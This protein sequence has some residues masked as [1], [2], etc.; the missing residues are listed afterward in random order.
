MKRP[1]EDTRL[2][3]AERERARRAAIKATNP[4][5][6]AKDT[7]GSRVRMQKHRANKRKHQRAP[8]RRSGAGSAQ[9]AAAPSVQTLAARGAA[10]RDVAAAEILAGMASASAP[11]SHLQQ[12]HRSA[13]AQ[14]PPAGHR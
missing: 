11:A 12:Q 5:R 1:S 13:K 3:N 2:K 4:E 6:H 14:R 9:Q 7:E 10:A 8:A